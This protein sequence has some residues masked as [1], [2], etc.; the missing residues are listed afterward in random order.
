MRNILSSG[1]QVWHLL[2][3][4]I[5]FVLFTGGAVA[6]ADTDSINGFWT[7]GQIRLAS[8]YADQTNTIDISGTGTEKIVLST[9]IDV[10]AGKKADL[11]TTFSA[12]L[13][14][15]GAQGATTYAYCFGHFGLDNAN[16]DT[17][18]HPDNYQLLGGDT[19][20]EPGAVTV[21]MTGVRKNVGS[22]THTVNVYV[23]AAYNGCTLFARNLHVVANI[24]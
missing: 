8:A 14:H 3:F 5:I 23:S 18:F 1:L 2:V 13:H 10:P 11:Q 15:N 9:T 4:G 22:G 7:A 17:K 21:T 24:R 19:D 20:H 12:D 6:L 16:P